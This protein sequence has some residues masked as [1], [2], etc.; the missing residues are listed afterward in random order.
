MKY[1]WKSIDI[2]IE[3]AEQL[4]LANRGHPLLWLIRWSCNIHYMKDRKKL[5][6]IVK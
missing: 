3:W 2:F 6:K 1:Q 4:E 5:K